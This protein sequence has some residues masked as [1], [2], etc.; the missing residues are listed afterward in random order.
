[1]VAL[2]RPPGAGEDI[3]S[4]CFTTL[5]SWFPWLLPVYSERLEI[6]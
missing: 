1:M 6:P 4:L 5:P 3:C 2:K